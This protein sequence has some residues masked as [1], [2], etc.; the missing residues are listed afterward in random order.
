MLCS[1]NGS[2]LLS[3]GESMMSRPGEMARHGGGHLGHVGHQ[4]HYSRM[5][6]FNGGSGSN[7]DP[8]DQHNHHHNQVPYL[9]S[10]HFW[11]PPKFICLCRQI[12]KG[13]DDL[14]CV[15]VQC[16]LYLTWIYSRVEGGSKNW[17]CNSLEERRNIGCKHFRKLW[18]Y[19][20]SRLRPSCFRLKKSAHT[21]LTSMK[22]W[23]GL[24]YNTCPGSQNG[25]G[26]TWRCAFLYRFPNF[27]QQQ[28]SHHQNHHHHQ[29]GN[30]NFNSSGGG[31][32][33]DAFGNHGHQMRQQ[34]RTGQGSPFGANAS[35]SEQAALAAAAAAAAANGKGLTLQNILDQSNHFDLMSNGINNH[36]QQVLC[37]PQSV[38]QS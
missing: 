21:T 18:N 33:H 28:H 16:G 36:H 31:G 1:S 26:G 3:S 25:R 7:Q 23:R 11:A 10:T 34:Q 14:I 19:G 30:N 22:N 32:G 4:D 2:S 38:N 20:A 8:R 9:L 15:W 12:I 35:S 13:P 24:M 27:Q 29:M 6:M 37:R 5:G 17:R